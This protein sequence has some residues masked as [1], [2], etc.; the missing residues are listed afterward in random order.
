MDCEYSY[1]PNGDGSGKEKPCCKNKKKIEEDNCFKDKCPLI[2]YCT[3]DERFEQ[4]ADMFN[5]RYRRK[6]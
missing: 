1:Y 4:T 5:C 3:I 2:Y 6:V